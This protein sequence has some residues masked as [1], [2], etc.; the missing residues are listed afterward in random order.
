[1]KKRFKNNV[2]IKKKAAKIYKLRR[3]FY[4]TWDNEQLRKELRLDQFNARAKAILVADN[5]KELE[6]KY[7][8]DF[9]I[10]D[11]SMGNFTAS[12][13]K[14]AMK[15]V[16]NSEQ[17]VSPAERARNNLMEGI[18]KSFPDTYKNI[19]KQLR[20][21]ERNNQGQIMG[22]IKI[23]YAEQLAWDKDRKAYT[24]YGADGKHYAINVDNSPEDIYLMEI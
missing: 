11:V 17:F 22:S 19:R 15:K 12:Q 14:I 24:F 9:N 1:M 7:G 20:R 16:A 23:N 5:L 21:Y 4:N 6:K 2:A 8:K 10:D 18:R 3:E 13:V